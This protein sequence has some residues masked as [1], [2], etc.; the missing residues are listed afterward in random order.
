M[1][2]SVVERQPTL[3]EALWQTRF[4]LLVKSGFKRT[5]KFYGFL[6]LAAVV[7]T[8]GDAAA[9][10]LVANTKNVGDIGSWIVGLPVLVYAVR[11]PIRWTWRLVV[12]RP[13]VPP[14]ELAEPVPADEPHESGPDPEN[15]YVGERLDTGEPASLD[16]ALRHRHLYVI[17]KSGTGKTTLLKRLIIQDFEAGRGVAV[18]DPH[19]DLA[20]DLLS[21]VPPERLDDVV[22][23]DPTS[24]TCPGFN[25]LVLAFDPAKLQADIVSAFK[26]FFG[27][28]WGDRLEFLL[29]YSL[30]TLLTDSEPHTLSDLRRLV[31][32]DEYRATIVAR[33]TS[34]TLRDFWA[35]Q[36][37][38]AKPSI[39]ALTNKLGQFLMPTS[40]LERVFSN[41][42]NELDFP[43]IMNDGKIFIANLAKG[44]IGDDPS[45]LLGG[46]IATG[47][48]QAALARAV[49]PDSERRAF[50]LYVD[51]FQ[52][53]CVASFETILS[54][55]R[56]YK[57]ALVLANQTLGQ[58]PTSLQDA[59]F[60]NVATLLSF[61]VSHDDA[62]RLRR[63]MH[64]SRIIVRVKERPDYVTLA[65]FVAYQKDLYRRAIEDKKYLGM[66]HEERREYDAAFDSWQGAMAA[67]R[68]Y[69]ARRAEIG[70]V[71]E[72]L[73]R[74][75][76]TVNVLRE[77][78]RD[79]EFREE[80]F[81]D[82]DDFLNLPPHHGLCRVERADNVFPFRAPFP[83]PG[84][85]AR[86]AA[87]LA[88]QR[89]EAPPAPSTTE[90][91]PATS[92]PQPT[93]EPTKADED[94]HFRF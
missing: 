25:P 93:L 62:T 84:D 48:Q 61:A 58:L 76:L 68:L 66:S 37:E 30:L 3:T 5:L 15:L 34:S 83:Q 86:R 31:V 21:Y 55:A 16:A 9:R 90:P 70:R 22:Y 60:G 75:D 73:D 8:I 40:P 2:I 35:Y 94:F 13:T 57:L 53:Y 67:S 38:G 91:S 26:M 51:E 14:A 28:S 17:G 46:L 79:Y 72:V 27:S 71:M 7:G 50:T 29:S 44:Q 20:H 45:R 92:S 54:E 81:P 42:R 23:F 56:K 74:P 4:G 11:R 18:I 52:N 63:E 1:A 6:L 87:I 12:R 59:I 47:V 65:D 19:G 78:F 69:N 77:L 43:R 89:D 33:V 32:S 24:P 85:P 80:S 64:R 82:V 41:P 39:P 88:R 49:L 36:F 10:A